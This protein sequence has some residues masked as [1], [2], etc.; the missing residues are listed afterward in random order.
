[1]VLGG[2][3]CIEMVADLDEMLSKFGRVE[4]ACPHNVAMP[5]HR[6]F[7]VTCGN[8]I[9]CYYYYSGEGVENA[10]KIGSVRLHEVIYLQIVDPMVKRVREIPS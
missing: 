9:H 1:M 3:V 2:G 7:S 6:C 10:L 5:H 4:V 8:L